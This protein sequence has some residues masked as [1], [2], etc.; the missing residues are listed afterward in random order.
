MNTIPGCQNPGF[1]LPIP[2]LLSISVGIEPLAKDFLM[3]L[4]I[5]GTTS[6]I[7]DG[8]TVA[9]LLEYQKVKMPDM[10]SVE[11]NGEILPRQEFPSTRLAEGD[12]IEFL[13]FMGG[14]SR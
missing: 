11:R 5:N 6:E 14:G 8:L 12:Q 7:P 3:N 2:S 13:Y 1:R 9:G 4:T 10:V